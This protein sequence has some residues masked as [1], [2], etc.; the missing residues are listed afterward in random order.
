V[1]RDRI[2]TKGDRI[3]DLHLWQV[4]PGHCAAVISVISDNPLSPATYKRRLG[5]LKRLCHVTV[6]VERCPHE[7]A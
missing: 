2:E 7:A 3:T 5:G 1:I 6:E 4:G